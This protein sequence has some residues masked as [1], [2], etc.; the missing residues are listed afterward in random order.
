MDYPQKLRYD[1]V[2]ETTYTT[3]TGAYLCGGAPVGCRTFA[4]VLQDG[5]IFDYGVTEA[6]GPGW[7][8]GI[9]RYNTATNTITRIQI[10]D[11]S[12]NNSPVNWGNE[13]K[14]IFLTV[15]GPSLTQLQDDVVLG[16]LILG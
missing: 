10:Y 14:A 2:K 8:N 11:S 15:N 6:G 1:R 5:D 12:N 3:G 4:S 7:E 9:G 16:S 13:F